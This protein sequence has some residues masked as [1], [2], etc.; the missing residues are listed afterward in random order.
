MPTFPR[1]PFQQFANFYGR[2]RLFYILD[3]LSESESLFHRAAGRHEVK[4][5]PAPFAHLGMA[6]GKA[7]M[8]PIMM[9]LLEKLDAVAAASHVQ[10]FC[11]QCVMKRAKEQFGGKELLYENGP[12]PW[13]SE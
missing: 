4:D 6:P 9:E 8:C 5:I 3:Q 10:Q 11:F 2:T 13:I 1:L 7:E 12:P